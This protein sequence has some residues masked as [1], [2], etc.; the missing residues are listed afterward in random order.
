MNR[1]VVDR[2]AADTWIERTIEFIPDFMKTHPVIR[3]FY[4]DA[5]VMLHGSITMGIVDRYAD[6]DLWYLLPEDRL[7]ELDK[8][9][10]SRF[11]PFEIDGRE[12]HMIAEDI[13]GFVTDVRHCDMD[14]I[15]QLRSAVTI[16]DE[17]G[18][19]I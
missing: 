16:F 1:I 19:E 8:V 7:R 18:I 14:K 10:D 3:D 13:N 6:I 15:Y 11:F 2:E 17:S 12:G 9:S 5:T 4:K